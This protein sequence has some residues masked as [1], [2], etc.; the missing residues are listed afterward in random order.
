MGGMF[1]PRANGRGA[2]WCLAVGSMTA[3]ALL[4]VTAVL[5]IAF[6]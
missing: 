1:W 6:R 5:V 2:A 3:A 4:V